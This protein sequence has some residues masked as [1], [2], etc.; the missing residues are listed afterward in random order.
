MRHVYVWSCKTHTAGRVV[1]REVEVREGEEFEP[2]SCA[3]SYYVPLLYYSDGLF[4]PFDPDDPQFSGVVVD[5]HVDLTADNPDFAVKLYRIGKVLVLNDS[6][7]ELY[8]LNFVDEEDARRA[9]E[10]AEKIAEGFDWKHFPSEL[11]ADSWEGEAEIYRY[12][13]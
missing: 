2:C 6:G 9:F 7:D 4:Q 11:F 1:L 5:D 12:R 3:N 13:R 8:I 10:K